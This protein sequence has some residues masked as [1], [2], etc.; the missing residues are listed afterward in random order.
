MKKLKRFFLLMIMLNPFLLYAQADTVSLSTTDK[1]A[2]EGHEG[3]GIQW[4]TGL[5]WEQIKQKAKSEN[6]YIFMD[7]YATWCGPC[8]SMDKEIYPD[9]K[10]GEIVNEKFIA[11]KVQMDSTVNDTKPIQKWYPA[12]R[13]IS[14]KYIF[15]GYVCFLFFY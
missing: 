2:T 5:S 14:T 8:K 4:T 12:V 15:R 3:K 11:V 1:V 9:E 6:K 13:E 10:V 7:C